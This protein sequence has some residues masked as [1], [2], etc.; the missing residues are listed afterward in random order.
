VFTGERA[1]NPGTGRFPEYG[2]SED[3]AY[4]FEAFATRVSEEGAGLKFDCALIKK[5]EVF[6]EKDL[7]SISF[8]RASFTDVDFEN[9]TMAGANFSEAIFHPSADLNFKNAVLTQANFQ[10]ANLAGV[11][12]EVVDFTGAKFTSAILRDSNFRYCTASGGTFDAADMFRAIV[13]GTQF[14]NASFV[15][16]DLQLADMSYCALDGAVFTDAKL[17]GTLFIQ[18]TCPNGLPAADPS[19]GGT[20]K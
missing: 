12:L 9:T 16:T 8:S 2:L 5:T 7:G 6:K 19:N 10:F 20:C 3:G 11:K 15:G 18:A 14:S 1:F 4:A 17:K 13:Q